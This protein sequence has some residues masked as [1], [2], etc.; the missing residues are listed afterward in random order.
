LTDANNT[1]VQNSIY[2]ARGFLIES[3]KPTW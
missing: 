3:T 2:V 1:M